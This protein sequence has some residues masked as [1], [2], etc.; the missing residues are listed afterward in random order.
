M[1]WC[2]PF[3]AGRAWPVAVAWLIS[4][5]V[6]GFCR[7]SCYFLSVRDLLSGLVSMSQT[8]CAGTNGPS[9]SGGS[10]RRQDIHGIIWAHG[11][12]QSAW[13]AIQRN[14]GGPRP[15]GHV[16][17]RM[18]APRDAMTLQMRPGEESLVV[19]SLAIS[20]GSRSRTTVAD[21]VLGGIS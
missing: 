20:R 5:L 8:L 12:W 11:P 3:L 17:P 15:S 13:R 14:P 21:L 9:G 16:R 10:G 7:C 19:L 1:K 4:K 18:M 2:H 6:W